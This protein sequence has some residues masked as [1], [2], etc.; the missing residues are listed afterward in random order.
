MIKVFEDFDFT[1]VGRMQSL[2]ESEGIETFMKNEFG[3]SVIGEL[4]FVEVVPQLYVVH[5]RDLA[6][7]RNLIELDQSTEKPAED[8]TCPGCD[9]VNPPAFEFCWHCARERGAP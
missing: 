1:L 2:L 9:S 3:S 6:R 5:E 8:W 7:A 4:P